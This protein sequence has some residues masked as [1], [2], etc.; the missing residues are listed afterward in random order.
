[1]TMTLIEEAWTRVREDKAKAGAIRLDATHQADFFGAQDEQGRLGLVLVTQDRP[2]SIPRLEAIDVT[3]GERA[4]GRWSIGIWLVAP[5]LQTPFSQ[6]CEDLVE[7]SRS[8]PTEALSAFV[9]RRLLRWHELLESAVGM[10]L[11]KLRGL[12]AELMVLRAA[13]ARFGESDAVLGWVGPYEAPQD[14]TLPGLWIEVKATVASARTV[15]I[16]SADQLAA[17]GPL[18]LAVLTMSTL[19]PS[20]PGVTVG[21]LVD[22]I[23]R[24]L[25]EGRSGEIGVEMAR[26]LSAVG[27]D[28][29]ADYARLPFRI[30]SVRY[31]EV[32]SDFPRLMPEDLDAGIADVRYDLELGVLGPFS[33]TSPFEG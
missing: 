2:P 5:T 21:A 12:I 4:D 26:R 20:E 30:E 13:I 32:R 22:D 19:L 24:Q 11:T 10:S 3:V 17:A 18:F 15:R 27:F 25:A 6:L 29:G 1:V 31:F 28:S 7:S 33:S 14:F 23:E 8:V 16:T 9:V